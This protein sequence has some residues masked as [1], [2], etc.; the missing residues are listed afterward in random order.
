[1]KLAI[2]SETAVTTPLLFT[3]AMALLLLVQVP[4]EEGDSVVE[5]PMH[6][7]FEPEIETTGFGLT[8]SGKL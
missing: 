2:P 6:I 3:V 7:L 4:S 5:A 8:V 1:L